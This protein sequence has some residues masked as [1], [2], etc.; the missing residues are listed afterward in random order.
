M[1]VSDCSACSAGHKV[2]PS[3]LLY[4]LAGL[5]APKKADRIINKYNNNKVNK[6]KVGK[7]DK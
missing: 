2:F 1:S 7:K 3:H 6:N 4:H 5:G